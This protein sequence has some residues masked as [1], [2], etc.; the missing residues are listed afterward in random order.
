MAVDPFKNITNIHEG[1]F[2]DV[3]I[4][5]LQ[6][7][8]FPETFKRG[9]DNII[10]VKNILSIIA[11]AGR[12]NEI[13][14]R[15]YFLQAVQWLHGETPITNFVSVPQISNLESIDESV[16]ATFEQY[17]SVMLQNIR[18]EQI[19]SQVE[20]MLAVAAVTKSSRAAERETALLDSFEESTA[21]IVEAKRDELN[22]SSQQTLESI[23]QTRVSIDQHLNERHGQIN[24]E[25]SSQLN[26]AINRFQQAQALEDWGK[27]YDA[28]ILEYE[29]R[30]FGRHMADGT[31]ARNIRALRGKIQR[32]KKRKDPA[33][34]QFLKLVSLTSKNI[35]TLTKIIGSRW[36][37]YSA[38]RTINFTLLVTLVI[39][40]TALSCASS[41]NITHIG[42]FKLPDMGNPN[43]AAWHLRLLIYLPPVI[44]LG[45]AYSFAVKN[46]RIYSNMLDQYRHRRAVARTSQGVILSL[47]PEEDK[48]VRIQM[49]SAAALALFEMRNTGHL[50]KKEA[51]SLSLI[52]LLK[53][54]R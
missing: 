44:L 4:E 26:E 11:K 6:R 2:L 12:L 14:G 49:T 32:S 13:G 21:S 29:Y 43:S 5:A 39:A 46:Y 37:S 23:E 31:V 8:N 30:L 19:Y 48:D 20:M 16:A 52:D 45:L 33:L 35:A 47:R 28:D 36:T 53:M 7:G 50:T 25:M 22:T 38:K 51:E 34:R 10:Q 54:G 40:V 18:S 17:S 24:Q 41:F 27:V 9:L 42:N 15:I 1:N 3:R